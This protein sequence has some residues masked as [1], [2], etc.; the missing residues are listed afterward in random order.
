MLFCGKLPNHTTISFAAAFM[1]LKKSDYFR[2]N[3]SS[4]L[5]LLD[6]ISD[7]QELRGTFIA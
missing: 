4:N 2:Y 1:T 7:I 5:A 6:Q 3:K